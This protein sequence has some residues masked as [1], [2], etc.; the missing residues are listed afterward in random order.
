MMKLPGSLSLRVGFLLVLLFG[1]ILPL[2]LVGLW[3]NRSAARSGEE[4][5]RGRLERGLRE[6][7]AG[8]GARWVTQRTTLLEIAEHPEVQRALRSL[9]AETVDGAP[10]AALRELFQR[11]RDFAEAV[12]VRDRNGAARWRMTFMA[13]ET[14]SGARFAAVLPIDLPIYDGASGARIGTLEARLLVS[15][16]ICNNLCPNFISL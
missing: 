5:V 4:L 6:V 8:I 16:L 9:A 13:G 3:L 11:A 1:A 15:R 2:G 7:S 12:A 14:P 10:P